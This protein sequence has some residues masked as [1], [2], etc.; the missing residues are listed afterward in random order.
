MDLQNDEGETEEREE[1]EGHA[2]GADEEKE[3]NDGAVAGDDENAERL[4]SATE[5]VPVQEAKAPPHHVAVFDMRGKVLPQ[6]VEVV[7]DHTMLKQD[8]EST[9]LMLGPMSYLRIHL[10]EEF[11][12][13]FSAEKATTRI[14]SY[15]L[16]MDIRLPFVTEEGISLYQA[17]FPDYHESDEAVLTPIGSIEAFNNNWQG[18]CGMFHLG[19]WNRVVVTLSGRFGQIDH[20]Q[21]VI[22]RCSSM[23]ASATNSRSRCGVTA[24]THA[25]RYLPVAS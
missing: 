19:K 12:R 17:A 13:G 15:T 22:E 16:T 23:G 25:F 7:G 11:Q 6:G 5:G 20:K 3:E 21:R 14:N 9:V 2:E 10:P 1:G 18:E 8:D 4:F 24:L